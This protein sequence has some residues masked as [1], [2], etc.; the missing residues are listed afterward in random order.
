MQYKHRIRLTG[1]AVQND[2]VLL[3]QHINPHTGRLRW[4]TPGGGMEL[5][6]EDMFRGV[7]RE[8]YEETGL[9]VQAGRIRF[10]NEFFDLRHQTLMADIWIQ[11]HPAEG[12]Q[13]GPVSMEHVREDD[14]IVDVRWWDKTAFL[15]A[16]HNANAPLLRLDFWDNLHEDTLPTRHLG[17]WEE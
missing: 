6:D 7:E 8:M 5:S 1:L 17:R 16:D 3:V 15:A 10:I 14:Y 4:S 9:R 2:Q 13:F 11:C 12:D